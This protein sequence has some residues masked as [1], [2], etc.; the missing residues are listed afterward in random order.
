MARSDAAQ[1]IV[2]FWNN[3]GPMHADRVDAV[4]RAMG[5]GV[6]CVGLEFRGTDE[7]YEWLSESRESFRKETLFA[8]RVPGLFGRLRALIG[9]ARRLQA[10]SWFLCHYQ[11]PEVLCLALYL[12][13][14]GR[15]VFTMGDSKFDDFPRSSSREFFKHVF[16][17][18]YNGAITASRRSHD[19]FRFLGLPAKNLV[20]GYDTL[21]IERI[22]TASKSVPAPEGCPFSER[23]FMIVA[24]HVPKKNL[25]VALEAFAQFAKL[26]PTSQRKLHLCGSGEG[27]AALRV[28][29]TELGIE[30]RVVFHGF[31]QTND[32]A[33]Q[34]ARG[35]A[36]V[37]P[38]IEEQFGLVVIEAQAM[39]LPVLISEVAGA[40]DALVRNWQN[41]FVFEP[42]NPEALARFMA[43]LDDDEALWRRLCAGASASAPLGD[44]AAFASGVQQ[45]LELAAE[46]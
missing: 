41:G 35:L 14:S 9:A 20:A 1:R 45:L 5:D 2:F 36:L 27:E 43:L 6:D 10:D 22:R 23:D 3:F 37:L 46:I 21:S 11:R 32:V 15:H 8:E 44:V 13:L 4:A 39:G 16:F 31:L 28:Q 25:H 30:D 18:P 26:R 42:D 17:L 7:T 34:L 12:R 24:R 38:S 33:K 40:R 29:T 19:Y